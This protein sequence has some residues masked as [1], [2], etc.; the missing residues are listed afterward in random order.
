[1][2][3]RHPPD[4]RRGRPGW[5][6]PRTRRRITHGPFPLL[7]LSLFSSGAPPRHHLQCMAASALHA[8]QMLAMRG[9]ACRHRHRQG[10]A[11]W[12]ELCSA[13]HANLP[14]PCLSM[15]A[16]ALANDS[17]ERNGDASC[18]ILDARG[19]CIQCNAMQCNAMQS[20][21][22]LRWMCAHI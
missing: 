2:T 15:A 3:G 14:F 12:L 7:C 21:F 18:W 22:L 6:R 5:S 4:L 10:G 13:V 9:V 8:M 11:G 16:T 20:P 17:E 19:C 1:L